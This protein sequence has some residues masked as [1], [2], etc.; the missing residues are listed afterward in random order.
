MVT[1]LYDLTLVY[2]VLI[3]SVLSK[4][5]LFFIGALFLFI[6]Q[7][8][9]Q[10]AQ[11]GDNPQMTSTCAEA[12]VICDIDGFTG[13]NNLTAMGQGFNEFCTTEYNNM[14]YI[15]F[16]AGSTNL[17]IRVDV[18]SCAGGLNSL[19]V[20]FFDS[21]DCEN[22]S[23]I[24]ICDTDI[25]ANSSQEFASVIPLVIGQHYYL[26]IDGSN[27]ANCNW[28][29][30]VLEGSTQVPPLTSSGD[31]IAPTDICPDALATFSTTGQ[32]GAAIYNW[33][34][35]GVSQISTGSTTTQLDF[36]GDGIFEV[37]VTASNACSDAPPTCT[38]VE[39]ITPG[40]LLIDERL[41]EGECIIANGVQYCETGTFQELIPQPSGCDSVINIELLVLET[42]MTDVTAL[43]CNG[44]FFEVGDTLFGTEGVFT[45]TVLTSDECDSIVTLDLTVI[46][47]EIIITPEEI[48]VICNGTAT[49]TL[50][51]SVDQG[52]PPLTWTYTNITD[53]TITG[54]GMTDLL[55]N[56]Q[57]PNIPV[58]TYNIYVS[59]NFGNDAVVL[60]VVT[61]P[62]VLESVLM[63]SIINGF[64]LSC[65]ENM[66]MPGNDGTLRVNAS[67][68]VPP[69]NY[70]WSNGQMDQTAV[71]LL[72]ENYVVTITDNVGCTKTDDL[73]LVA[74]PVIDPVVDFRDP[75]CSGFETGQIEVTSITGGTP[76][77]SYS[78]DGENFQETGFFNGLLEGE[79]E[80]QIID[81][82]GCVVMEQSEIIAP[83]IPVILSL[84]DLTIE[85]GCDQSILPIINI[86]EFSN[87]T[88]TDSSTLNCGNCLTPIA[89]PVNNTEY[90]LMVTSLDDCSTEGTMKIVVNKNRPVFIPNVFSPDGDGLNDQFTIHAG[91]EVETI[92]SL[93]I[94]NRWGAVVYEGKD[95]A[96]N[97][98]DQGWDGNFRGKQAPN[99]VYVYL[100]TVKFVDGISIPYKGD[101]AIM[102]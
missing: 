64:N 74:P 79:Y 49:G 34:I 4:S 95:I 33:T 101:V 2:K 80:I 7:G 72:A 86:S 36:P 20:G 16:I 61:E 47:C 45:H 76:S 48:P 63:P 57:I 88:W 67:G 26:V 69:Y 6:P 1:Y 54:T 99:G 39:A 23:Q 96:P 100:A 14:Q 10:P 55:V 73:T 78:I 35:N 19:E 13:V 91:K 66:G 41:C 42:A 56:N 50:V 90:T 8:N 59:D 62:P 98:L 65:A 77:Y 5:L 75:N 38:T 25:P 22:F 82:N 9:S 40:T 51:F 28:T 93:I 29:F 83:E 84:E 70:N 89:S 11:C 37:C 52:E 31:I 58:G 53:P 30:N 44:T 43:I 87:I 46:E 3:K 68:G 15:A 102:R 92:S 60:Q 17:R 81:E 94:F 18:G 71:G 97:D 27:G 12:C 24:T 85:L 21:P 32:V